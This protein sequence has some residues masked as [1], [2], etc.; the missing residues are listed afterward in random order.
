[1]IMLIDKMRIIISAG[2]SMC[3][4]KL[5]SSAPF[6][7]GS[8]EETTSD[9]LLKGRKTITILHNSQRYELRITRQNKLIL[10]K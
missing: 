4:K 10:T 7:T 9:A 3:Q 5:L 8:R 6:Q 2:T 1:M